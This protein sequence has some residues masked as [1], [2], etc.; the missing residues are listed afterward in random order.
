MDL[1]ALFPLTETIVKYLTVNLP[2]FFHPLAGRDLRL[3]KPIMWIVAMHRVLTIM[4][5]SC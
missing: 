4:P 5:S 1:L 2:S 3:D